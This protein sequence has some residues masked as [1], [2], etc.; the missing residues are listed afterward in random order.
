MNI[1]GHLFALMVPV[2]NNKEDVFSRYLWIYKVDSFVYSVSSLWVKD[3]R[4]RGEISVVAAISLFSA[5]IF[6]SAMQHLKKKRKDHSQTRQDHIADSNLSSILNATETC[7][8]RA[9]T[10]FFC[11]H[12]KLAHLLSLPSQLRLHNSHCVR[13]RCHISAVC[14]KVKVLIST[15]RLLFPRHPIK[16]RCLLVEAVLCRGWHNAVYFP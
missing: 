7:H 3:K 16:Y 1:T 12:S 4:R 11:S 9:F 10:R 6:L 5:D 15:T 2:I 14:A 8:C 13:Y